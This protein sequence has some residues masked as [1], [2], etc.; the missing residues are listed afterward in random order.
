MRDSLDGSG[1]DLD[2]LFWSAQEL[3]SS[4]KRSTL[5]AQDDH[6]IVCHKY[7]QYVVVVL[8]FKDFHILG[9]KLCFDALLFS[10]QSHAYSFLPLVAP[11]A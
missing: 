11:Q 10:H 6:L 3:E 4:V 2:L 9:D 1:L 8:V 7:V 5:A